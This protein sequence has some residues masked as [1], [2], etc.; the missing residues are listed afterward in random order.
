MTIGDYKNHYQIASLPTQNNRYGFGA[1][2]SRVRSARIRVLC[3]PNALADKHAHEIR[4]IA[5][6]YE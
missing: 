2:L 5:M 1:V 3:Q 6:S 4:E